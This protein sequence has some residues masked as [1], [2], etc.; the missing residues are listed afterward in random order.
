[1][2]PVGAVREPG[3]AA[4]SARGAGWLLLSTVV[5]AALQL[6]SAAVLG[7]L[8]TPADFGVVAAALLVIRVVYYFSQ[9]GL[10]SALVQKRELSDGDVRAG[11]WLAI[12]IGS[13]ATVAGVLAA[14]LLAALLHQPGSVRVAQVLSVS[15]LLTGIATTPLALLRRSLRFRAVATVDVV[16]YALGYPVAG[17]GA[18]LAG[19][20][21]WS[22]VIA[23]LVQG[24]VQ[25]LGLLALAP[26]P[27]ALRPPAG[28]LAP[29]AGFGGRVSL[30]GVLEF[31]SLQLDSLGV[32]RGRPA[33]DL[34]QYTRGTLLAYPVVQTALVVTR[35]LTSAFARISDPGRLRQ[36]YRDALVLLATGS[37]TAAAVL[38]GGHDALVIGL[39]GG[40]WA[41]AAGI[42]PWLA[43]A[44]ALQALSQLPAVLCEARAVLWPKVWIQLTVLSL[45]GLAVVVAVRADA[46]LWTYAAC[47]CGSELVRQLL[48]LAVVRRLFALTVP[49]AVRDLG[50]A[51]VPAFLALVAVA[52]CDRLLGHAQTPIW[53]RLVAVLVLGSA[54]PLAAVA[55]W[56][57]CRLR[58]IV[59][60]RRLLDTVP[61]GGPGRRLLAR[62]LG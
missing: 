3:L 8:L 9:F 4:A 13:V 60:D 5:T 50:Q 52:G 62:A 33:A 24:T 47:W 39:L 34:G 37:L 31:W 10:G 35:V 61:F 23:A 36:A 46:P 42:L 7:R 6:V 53:V 56:P 20:G 17:L 45:F 1:V 18:V 15:F 29:L 21:L 28:A 32:A 55:C 54:V 26:H 40:Q 30:V 59:R 25:A 44:S 19:A 58:R 49:A 16:S 57:G 41:G 43:A 27:V 51:A 2:V 48:Y 12:V 14:P 11:A 38:A 22:L